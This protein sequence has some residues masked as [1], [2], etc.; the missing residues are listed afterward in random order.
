MFERYYT[1]SIIFISTINPCPCSSLLK[2]LMF[3]SSTATQI[4]N[5][6]TSGK[7]SHQKQTHKP[8]TESTKTV[9]TAVWTR[10]WKTISHGGLYKDK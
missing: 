10:G 3:S 7:N 2:K 9:T 8:H 1:F 5:R 6:N 4:P